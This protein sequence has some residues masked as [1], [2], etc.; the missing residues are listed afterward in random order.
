[1][2]QWFRGHAIGRSWW[3]RYKLAPTFV[4]GGMK[5]RRRKQKRRRA[6][7]APDPEW[8]P[9]LPQQ[10][11]PAK[12]LTPR[13]RRLTFS[14]DVLVAQYIKGTSGI[15]P[16][17]AVAQLD[18]MERVQQERAEAEA[19]ERAWIHEAMQLMRRQQQEQAGQQR[20]RR[21]SAQSAQSRIAALIAS[22]EG[23]KSGGGGGAKAAAAADTADAEEAAPTSAAAHAKARGALEEMGAQL[24]SIRMGLM[25]GT[26][27]VRV[28]EALHAFHDA[29]MRVRRAAPFLVLQTLLALVEEAIDTQAEAL[30]R[31][32][33]TGAKLTVRCL[34]ALDK[35][36]FEL[37][38]VS[39]AHR[40]LIA[41]LR[42]RH[43]G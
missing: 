31:G 26:D 30:A 38:Y 40:P 4:V 43:H 42:P 41:R 15:E 13:T 22:E 17:R 16:A 27:A 25:H 12:R 8:K 20:P 39:V 10:T 36:Y 28:G 37:L 9:P 32:G 6:P 2:R 34:C 24:S 11:P 19:E 1:M 23:A 33:T 35:V 3:M 14:P 7:R 21:V 5:K 18:D 29:A